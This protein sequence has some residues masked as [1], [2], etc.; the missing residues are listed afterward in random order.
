M[1]WVTVSPGLR[2]VTE[3]MAEPASLS[4][5]NTVPAA[6]ELPELEVELENAESVPS[7][8]IRPVMATISIVSPTFRDFVISDV[9]PRGG[10]GLGPPR[11]LVLR[12][13]ERTKQTLRGDERESRLPDSG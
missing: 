7:P 2:L 8:A 5:M 6:N 4:E 11:T 9:P 13:S 12:R 1:H 10:D 3:Y